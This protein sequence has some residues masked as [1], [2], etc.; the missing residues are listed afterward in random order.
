MGALNK[1]G[2]RRWT[3]LDIDYAITGEFDYLTALDLSGGDVTLTSQQS[4]A[5]ILEVTTGHASNAI[6]ISATDATQGKIYIVVNNSATLPANIKVAS[7]TAVSVNPSGKSV[8][9]YNGTN[10]IE[11]AKASS[12][13]QTVVSHNYGA[14]AVDWTL[15]AAELYAQTLKVTNAS[16]AVNAVLPATATN[17]YLVDNQSGQALTV[18]VTGQTGITVA[19]TKRAILWNNGTDVV[20][21]TADA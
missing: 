1:D 8:V 14:A 20:R 9:Y 10:Y 16:G 13:Y 11:I 7:G 17:Y 4:K 19:S 3:G 6:I 21:I 2:K 5:A 18:K 15:S 12:V